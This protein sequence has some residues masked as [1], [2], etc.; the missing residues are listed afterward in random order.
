MRLSLRPCSG[1]AWLYLLLTQNPALG[2]SFPISLSFVPYKMECR[3][4]PA[5]LPEELGGRHR[6]VH[7]KTCV[8]LRNQ[9]HSSESLVF[10]WTSGLRVRHAPLVCEHLRLRPFPRIRA[11]RQ[12]TRWGE[13]GHPRLCGSSQGLRTEGLEFAAHIFPDFSALCQLR[14]F[15]SQKFI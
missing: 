14:A 12:G 2:K 6:V 9:L 13:G 3:P 1:P 7:A 15:T 8:R 11:G 5:Y 10:P 4:C